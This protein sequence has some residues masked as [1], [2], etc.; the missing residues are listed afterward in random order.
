[1]ED[2]VEEVLRITRGEGVDVVE[3][4]IGADY[5]ARNLAVLKPAGT[6]LLV[7]LMGGQTARFD[8]AGC[9][10]SA[11]PSAGSPSA[12]SPSP[13]SGRS[14]ALPR[15]LAPASSQPGRSGPSSTPRLPFEEVRRA[16]EMMEADENF[17]KII[18]TFD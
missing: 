10:A 4:F 12:P 15:A 5:L 16:H 13:T 9:C 8:S 17:G 18:L 1:M 3:D 2:F 11:S 7:G 14:S 6:L